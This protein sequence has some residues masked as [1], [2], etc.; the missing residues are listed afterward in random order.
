MPPGLSAVFRKTGDARVASNLIQQ[1]Q[2]EAGEADPAAFAQAVADILAL[3]ESIGGLDTGQGVGV[4]AAATGL[5]ID[6]RQAVTG[7]NNV[8]FSLMGQGTPEGRKIR[9]REGISDTDLL[10]AIGQITERVQA[11]SITGPE[12][13]LLGGREAAPT[14]AALSDPDIYTG[15]AAKVQRVDAVEDFAGRISQDKAERITGSSKVQSYNLLIKQIVAEEDANRSNDYRALQIEAARKALSLKLNKRVQREEVVPLESDRIKAAFDLYISRGLSIEAALNKADWSGT[16]PSVAAAP[17][18]PEVGLEPTSPLGQWILNPP[19]LP[20][21]HSGVGIAPGDSNA[22]PPPWLR[23]RGD[24][25][26]K[27]GNPRQA[28]LPR[29]TCPACQR[30]FTWRKKWERDWDRV[31]YCSKACAARAK[32]GAGRSDAQGP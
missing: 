12:L 14:F 18:I 5:S 2:T 9:E 17:A 28:D 4:A 20:I 25:P 26:M 29:K 10:L 31:K 21:P 15:F 27:H 7:F 24:A 6:T 19:R 32:R 13:E 3:S 1:G 11:G 16:R 8:M 30:A 22:A 23:S